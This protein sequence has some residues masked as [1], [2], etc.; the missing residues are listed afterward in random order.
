MITDAELRELLNEHP[1]ATVYV[2][3]VDRQGVVLRN[4]YVQDAQYD[5]DND[6]VNIEVHLT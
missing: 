1:D 6:E 4:G 2:H 3:E 5:A